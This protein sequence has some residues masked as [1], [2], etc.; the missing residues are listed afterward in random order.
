MTGTDASSDS[1]EIIK[2]EMIEGIPVI[3]DILPHS[4]EHR[5]GRKMV[6][7]YITIHNTANPDYG[8]DA[9]MHSNYLHGNT[10]EEYVSWHFTVDDST[11]YEHLPLDEIGYHAGDGSSGDGNNYSI[12]IEICENADGDYPLAE[13]NAINLVAELLYELNMDVSQVVPHKHWS[14]KECPHNLLYGLKGSIGWN[15]FI[16]AVQNE[17]DSLIIEKSLSEDAPIILNK[18]DIASL[19]ISTSDDA[20]I[21]Q[22]EN[23]ISLEWKPSSLQMQIDG[24]DMDY[25]QSLFLVS[26]SYQVDDIYNEYE[27]LIKDEDSSIIETGNRIF[28]GDTREFSG[29]GITYLTFIKDGE[30]AKYLVY[31]G[32]KSNPVISTNIESFLYQASAMNLLVH[33]MAKDGEWTI[34]DDTVAKIID[35][36]LYAYEKGETTIEYTVHGRKFSRDIKVLD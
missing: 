18:G 7:Q 12:A 11:V 30:N 33:N 1:G 32:I 25:Y 19:T 9:A 21:S 10:Q 28:A 35:G 23:N 2:V 4:K 26:S 22:Y 15:G 17:L 8:A 31:N 6:P 13:K 34:Q 3:K 24:L 27:R 36:K 14:G 29:T 20:E 5:P 16:D